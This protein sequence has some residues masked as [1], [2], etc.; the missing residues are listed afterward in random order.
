MPATCIQTRLYNLRKKAASLGMMSEESPAKSNKRPAGAQNAS[1]IKKRKANNTGDDIEPDTPAKKAQV[2]PIGEAKPRASPRKAI[3]KDYKKLCDPFGDDDTDDTK[4]Q[5]IRVKG[6]DERENDI[7]DVDDDYINEEQKEKH[8][9][10]E[11]MAPNLTE[12]SPINKEIKPFVKSE[13]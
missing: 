6:E 3:N 10:E 2:L 1:P 4:E 5:Q 13:V 12:Y 7:D 9:N 11:K 8:E